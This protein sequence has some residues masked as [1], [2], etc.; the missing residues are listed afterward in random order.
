MR[1]PDRKDALAP[2]KAEG[3]APA[4]VIDVGVLTGTPDLM[5]AF[6]GVH[7]LP[8]EPEPAHAPAIAKAYAGLSH[9]W[10]RRRRLIM[11]V[12]PC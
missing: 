5:A 6:P 7:H 12:K 4:T 9:I 10:L 2:L 1:F 3:L 8:I 11:R